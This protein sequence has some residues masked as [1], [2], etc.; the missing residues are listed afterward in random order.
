MLLTAKQVAEKLHVSV[1]TVRKMCAD[2]R[3]PAQNIAK[4]GATRATW[5]ID[6]KAFREWRSAQR[7]GHQADAAVGDVQPAEATDVPAGYISTVAAGAKLRMTSSGILWRVKRGTLAGV[8]VGNRY[9]VREADLA[10]KFA[11][12]PPAPKAGPVPAAD[13]GA[14]PRGIVTL[15]REAIERLGRLENKVDALTRVWS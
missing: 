5:R 12:Q 2:G 11:H 14:E 3:L 7:N 15:L 8:R 1:H 10:V 9:F 6:E 4:S 13:E